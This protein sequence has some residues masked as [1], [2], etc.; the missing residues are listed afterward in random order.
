MTLLMKTYQNAKY[1]YIQKIY[2]LTKQGISSYCHINHDW[3]KNTR[4]IGNAIMTICVL[5]F[6]VPQI[7]VIRESYLGNIR[8]CIVYLPVFKKKTHWEYF[9]TVLNSRVLTAFKI[10]FSWSC[11]YLNEMHIYF[12]ELYINQCISSK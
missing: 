1:Q 10:S 12:N 6:E 11:T 9:L 8:Y 5:L 4:N 7:N 2:L 3:K